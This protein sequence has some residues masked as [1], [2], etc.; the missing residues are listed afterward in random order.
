[1][2]YNKN[3]V[4]DVNETKVNKDNVTGKNTEDVYKIK[5]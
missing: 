5:I 2:K 4:G 1:M 3:N